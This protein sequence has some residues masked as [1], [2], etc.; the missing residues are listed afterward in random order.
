MND[1][2]IQIIMNDI[3]IPVK[4]YTIQSNSAYFNKCKRF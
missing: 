1:I 3:D 4:I 2:D